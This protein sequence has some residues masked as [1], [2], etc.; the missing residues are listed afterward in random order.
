MTKQIERNARGGNLLSAFELFRQASNDSMPEH[1]DNAEEWFE[2]CWKYLQNGG[3]TRDGVYRPENNFCLR[4][5]ILTDFRRFSHLPVRFEED[6]TIIIGSNGQGKSSILSA[7]A[8]TL[9]WFT[10]S[11]LKEDGSGQRLNEFS[12][13][14]NGSENQFTDI[15]SHFSFGK[16]LKNIQLRLSRS[17]PGAAQKRDSEIKSAK[18][19]ADICRVVNNKCTIN[20]PVFAFYGVERSY[21]FTKSR[22][23]FEKREDRFDAYTHA[24]TGAGRF[25]HFSEWFISLHKISGAQKI[26]DL[27]QLQEQV[28]YLEKAVITGI[29]AVKPLLQEAQEKL[30]AALTEYEAKGSNDTLSA[31]IKM[32]IVSDAITSIVPS[33]SRI[34]VDTSTGSD[35]IRVIN[36]Q[37]NVTVDQLS[38]GQRV[39]LGLIADLTRRIIMLNP[40]L[41]NPLAGQGIV[42]IDEIE[43]H[44]HPKWQQEVIPNLRSVFPNIQFII[45]THS[46]IVLSTADRRCVREFT[47]NLAGEDQIL[48][49]PSIQTKGSENSEILEQ[50]MNVF[51]SPQN[52]AETHLLSEFEASL[53]ADEDN[54]SQDSQDLYNKIQSH[55]GLQSSQKH[56]ADSL[57]RLNKLKNKIRRSKSEGKNQG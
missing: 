55:F 19:I 2:L 11:I 44:L 8:K 23:K 26:A 20:L 22:T 24:L 57:M 35:I 47:T 7:I 32:G 4:S 6:L 9:S 1:H 38:D 13:I 36:D 33:I 15:S 50:V 12:D 31:E 21:S 56:K 29:S 41:S 34:W 48:D 25:D 53:T 10:A 27:H 42:L 54:L 3:D 45:S 30:K 43:L 46:P 37:L 16:G 51:S 39:F 14:R 17:V 5:M 52:I 40:L 18:E 49:M 28:S